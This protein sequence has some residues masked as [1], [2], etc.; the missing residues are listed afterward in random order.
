MSAPKYRLAYEAISGKWIVR[1][2]VGDDTWVLVATRNML[3]E[4]EDTIKAL[5]RPPAEREYD[6]DG[7]LIGVR[8]LL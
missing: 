5:A 2:Y 4:A 8:V 1:E 7:N 6:A 3:A